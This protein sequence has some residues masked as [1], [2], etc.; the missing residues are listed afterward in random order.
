MTTARGAEHAQ[1]SDGSADGVAAEGAAKEALGLQVP[2]R[3]RTSLDAV[4]DAL[5]ARAGE[6][7]LELDRLAETPGVSTLLLTA[8][9]AAPPLELRASASGDVT[10]VAQTATA[11]PGLHAFVVELARAL[12]EHVAWDWARAE[13][14]SGYAQSSDAAALEAYAAGWLG[15]VA[16]DALALVDSGARGLSLALPADVLFEGDAAML[17]PLGPRSRD[18]LVA[19][20]ADGL[21]GAD[22]LAWWTPGTGAAYHRDLASFLLWTEVRHRRPSDDEERA[23]FDRVLALLETA[24]ALDPSLA[25]PWRA[26]SELFELRGEQSLRATRVHLKA[27]GVARSAPVGYRRAPV[28]VEL[29]AGWSIRIPGELRTR[30]AEHGT[31]VAWDA[32]RTFWVTTITAQDART[33][34]ETLADLKDPDGSGELL[35]LEKDGLRGRG[36]FGTAD[37]GWHVLRAQAVV[38]VHA[39]LGTLLFED[40]RERDGVLEVWGSLEHPDAYTR[41]A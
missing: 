27:E 16:R 8:H 1:R 20:A 22:A 2:G 28:R 7:R 41:P 13:D 6:P 30:F 37:D 31:F 11:G 24:H 38:G 26:W 32:K 39:A 15:G 18:W 17:T 33:T 4:L 12:E 25:L 14:P 36:R 29:P 40:E 23:L 34:E 35:D 9:P 21:R 5:R 10:L 3:L 19:V